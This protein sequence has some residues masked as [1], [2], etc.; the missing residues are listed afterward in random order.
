MKVAEAWRQGSDR[1]S[2]QSIPDASLE[3]EVLLRH[4]LA[5]DRAD[6]FAALRREVAPKQQKVVDRSLARRLAGEPLF[7]IIGQRQFYSLDLTVGPRAMVPRQETELLVEEAL[8]LAERRAD[9]AISIADVGTGSGAIAIAVAKSLPLSQVYATD[10]SD[11]ALAVADEN[12][13]R[14][15]VADRVRLR[16]GDLL[17]ALDRPVDIIVSNP[18]YIPSGAIAG[19][20]P[21]VRRE[22]ALALDGGP[23]GMRTIRRLIA[24]APD[25]LNPGGQ[26]LVEIAPEQLETVMSLARHTFPWK[27]VAYSRDLLGMPRVVIVDTSE[28]PS[29]AEVSHFGPS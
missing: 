27:R 1:L 7:Y 28:Q 9:G 10:I 20:A 26:L 19:L 15:G 4:A 16:R 3:A 8:R 13:R 25:C 17:E 2:E 22:P 14:H 11:G 12:R 24:Q 5:V 6:F 29:P 18:P 23:D 21:E